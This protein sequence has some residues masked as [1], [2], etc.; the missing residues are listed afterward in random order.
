MQPLNERIAQARRAQGLTQ[1]QV[2]QAMNVSRQTVSQWETGR[3]QPDEEEKVRLLALL[4]LQEEALRQDEH[5]AEEPT[6]RKKSWMAAICCVAAVAVALGAAMMSRPAPEADAAAVLATQAPTAAP[7]TPGETQPYSLA[8]FKEAD[9][10]EAGKA[11]VRLAAMESPVLLTQDSSFAEQY[12]WKIWFEIEE[13]N[14]VD[15]KVEKFTEV[16]FN[17]EEGAMDVYEKIGEECA[18]YWPDSTIG[19]G[20]VLGYN[21]SRPVCGS[22]GYGAALE[23]TDANGHAR[24]FRIYIPLSQDVAQPV[25]MNQFTAQTE[26][27]AGGAHLTLHTEENPIPQVNQAFFDGDWGWMYEY[28]AENATDVPFTVERVTEALF[29]GEEAVFVSTFMPEQLAQWGVSN[30]VTREAPYVGS[31]AANAAQG[32]TGL[33]VKME[34]TDAQGHAL[35]FTAYFPFAQERPQP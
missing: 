20:A 30:I 11:F 19:G 29:R 26:P 4:H 10:N 16:F 32:L 8:W 24:T 9:E 18:R 1:E 3:M 28:V 21:I 12:V 22:I 15:F 14:G 25:T 5:P 35:A 6:A 7:A 13:M 17:R 34:G 31:G 2:A 27:Q 33:G 23:G